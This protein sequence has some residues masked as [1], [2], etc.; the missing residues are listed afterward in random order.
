MSIRKLTAECLQSKETT[1]VAT[2]TTIDGFLIGHAFATTCDYG[3]GAS[4]SWPS[5]SHFKSAT[6]HQEK[7]AGSRNSSSTRTHANVES[8]RPFSSTSS[9]QTT[10]L[11]GSH[12]HTLQHVSPPV[13]SHVSTLPSLHLI[14]SESSIHTL[15]IHCRSP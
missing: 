2:C 3:L 4:Q 11:S 9:G 8:P 12:H 6:V 1:E 5:A 7:Y 14:H 13:G 10:L 15:S